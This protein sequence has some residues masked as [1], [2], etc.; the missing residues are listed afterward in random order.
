MSK[1]KRFEKCFQG[2][3]RLSAEDHPK[4][5]LM[6]D[7]HRGTGT[8]A[9]NFI[10]NRPI[11]TA[12]LKFYYSRDFTYI[13]L[14]DGDELWENRRFGDVYNTHRE[15]YA[16]LHQ[17]HCAGRLFML[18]GN[19][20]RVKEKSAYVW[21]GLNP[22]IPFYESIIL[23]GNNI[24]PVYMFHGY[25]GDLINDRLW[26]VSRW[27]VRYLWRPLEIRGF[28]DPTSA[29]KNYTKVRRIEEDFI[30][31]SCEKSCILA[32]GHTHKPTLLKSGCGMYF[33]CGSCIHPEAITAI[34]IQEDRAS[35]V[36]W[37]ICS[38]PDMS[39]FVCREV[40]KEMP[41]SSP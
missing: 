9:D 23:E 2:A 14:G 1:Q 39:L 36:K 6:S 20:D 34:E 11:Y 40:L 3:L 13:E 21:K 24:P 38:N 16:L 29:A 7:C 10:R 30:R 12:A 5:V 8:W 27:M 17:F 32:A 31:Y 4:V 28:K 18:Y 15:I 25:Q 35:L 19:H 41:L 33:N 22:A 37:S 26:K